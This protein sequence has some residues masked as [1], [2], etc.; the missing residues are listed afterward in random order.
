M[1]L[2]RKIADAYE[3]AA[4]FATSLLENANDLVAAINT[5]LR[6][7]V[8]NAAFRREFELVFGRTV[9]LGQRLDDALGH[10][11]CDRNKAVML[12]RRALAGESFRVT[13][14]FGDEQLLRKTYEMAFSPI[15]DTHRQVLM[16]A[17]VIRDLTMQRLSEQRFG[18]LL[19]A[20]PDA[21]III[22]A[23]GVIDLANTHAQQMFQYE[24]Q[25]LIGLPIEMLLP[26]RLRASHI[27]H[28]QHFIS[29]AMGKRRVDLL[30]LRS[31]GTE[32]PVEISLNPL[33]V[34]GEKMVVGAMR[35]M[36]VRQR[37]ED[38]LRDLSF[39]LEQRVFDRTAALEQAN[40]V[41]RD[42]EARFHMLADNIPQLAWM[43]DETGSAFWHNKRWLEYTGPTP[44]QAWGRGWQQVHHP[45]HVERVV[46]KFRN[47]V[48]TGEEWEDT[49]PLRRH[50]GQYR[51]FLSR[52]LPIRDESGRVQQWFGTN[53]DIT[54][55]RQVE[56]AL[57]ESKAQLGEAL[58]RE[59]ALRAEMVDVR[60]SMSDIFFA[61]DS[62]W[63]ITYVNVAAERTIAMPRE[64][65]LGKNYWA[66][67]PAALGTVAEREFRRA[68]SQRVPVKFEIYYEPYG[69]WF[70][71]EAFP[72]K[73]G[74]LAEYARNITKRKLAEQA[75]LQLAAIVTSSDDAIIGKT[76]ECTIASWN[77]GA[78]RLFGYRANEMLGQS[79]SI[80]APP[81]LP[82]ETPDFVERLRRGER[83]VPHETV[84][85]RKD[86]RRIDVS[87]S[88]SPI[89]NPEGRVTGSSA[90]MRDISERKRAEEALRQ[91]EARIRRLVDANIIGIIFGNL[92]GGI[93]EAN[94]AF[95]KISGYTRQDLLSGN[96]RWPD[97]TPPEYRAADERALEEIMRTGSCT[98]FEKEYIR[99]DGSRIPVLV[100]SAMFEGSQD[101]GVGFVL[102]L[103]ARKQ[104]EEQV[105]HM[106]DHDALTGLPNRVLLQDRI[107]QAIATAHRNQRRV[108][109]LFIDLDYFKNINDSLGHHIGDEVLQM[110]STRL[111]QCL[112]EGDSVA[113]L[114]GD[115]FVLILPLL[116]DGSD[117]SR[118]AQKALDVLAQAF[119]V[120]GHEL[121]V[122][123]SIGISLYPDDGADVET[124]MR[125]ADTAMYHAKEMGRGNFQFFT[126]ALNQAAQQRFDLSTRLRQALAQNEFVLHYQ[127]QVKMNT[128]TIFSTEALLRWQ[129]PGSPPISCC[130]FIANAEESGLIVPIGEWALRQACRQ[131]RIWHDA[132]HPGLKMAVNLSPRQLEQAQFCSLVGQIL[133]ET[134]IP[135]TAL[136][137]EIT[138][139]ILMQRSEFN[140]ATLT[141]LGKMG[142]QL[143]VDDFGTGYSSLAYLQRFPVHALKIDQS[144]V[145]DLGIDSNDTALVTAII[146]MANSLHLKVI[147]EGVENWYQSQFLVANGCLAGQGFYYSKAVPAEMLSEL[148]R[149]NSNPIPR[150]HPEL[151]L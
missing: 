38:H 106:A 12:C 125:A 133:I 22:R 71:V 121:H 149:T 24:R 77:A 35:D 143:S 33:D 29:E 28:S 101:Q 142:I 32:F 53:T 80:L 110:A 132:G 97:M 34:G 58:D 124:L 73:N 37:A 68:M 129:P 81:E 42:S 41:Y 51:W 150:A 104:A 135:A 18:A 137:L 47:C 85:V 64:S 148:F 95:L 82:D 30:G 114:G 61:L 5:D 117:P 50:D 78:E 92:S 56:E 103:S 123:G 89:R 55:Q 136:E 27:T 119:I 7:V 20:A 9:E 115:E 127:P 91:K 122:S 94:D 86:G 19:E 138:E 16:A 3:E 99:K 109:I 60:E 84:R 25:Q 69:Q 116:G 11:T 65:L 146:A 75:A 126:P 26:E 83:I 66:V 98:P 23:D 134:G 74:G 14:Q 49:F 39:E 72:V 140:L 120:E 144:F 102:D 13:E 107:H 45:D 88:I 4:V 1:D 43:A 93:S 8:L 31:D 141:R 131:L 59:R 67:F 44:E 87:L 57:R 70:E 21:M 79:F 63:R 48:T 96:M 62:G 105:R 147:A 118:V 6:F 2:Q 54:E 90:I 10:V 100:A 113:R 112:R 130:D 52:A 46:E 139:S 111:Q 76:L 17:V 151:R 108:A 40:N 128:G 145:R 15:L 36:T